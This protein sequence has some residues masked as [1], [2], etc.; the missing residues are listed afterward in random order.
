MSGPVPFVEAQ[1]L[2]VMGGLAP[3][4]ARP[5]TGEALRAMAGRVIQGPGAIC[6]GGDPV[7]LFAS[8]RARIER[9]D[10]VWVAAEADLLN[11]EELRAVAGLD[12][13]PAQ[14]GLLSRLY[15]MEG[16]AFLRRLRGAFAVA[17]WDRRQ[18]A[19]LLA[20]DPF[21]MR[22]LYYAADARGTAFAS[23]LAAL[24]AGLAQ[25]APIEPAAIFSYLNFGFIP[26]PETPFTGI[27]RLPPGHVFHVR[28]G[29][30]KLEPYWDMS[31][32]EER[33]RE[34][35]AAATMYRLSHEAV[36]E[37][38][39]QTDPSEIG[40]FLSGGTDSSTVVGLMTRI[41]GGP[42]RSFSI[43]FHEDRYDELQYAKLAART[44]DATH[45]TRIIK[46]DDALDALPRLV[47]AYDEPFGNNSAIGV[48]FCARMAREHG[49]S[50]LL[51]GDG[52]DEIFGGNE[53]YRTDRIFARYSNLPAALRHGLLE[54]VLLGLPA[55]VP[56]LLGRAQ[57]YIRR[58]NIPNPRRFYSY[59]FHV[60]QNAAEMLEPSFLRQ[61]ASSGPWG[62][63]EEHF[64]R[65]QAT[66]ELNR[67]MYLDLKL[68][69]GD[70]DLFK[71]TRTSEL[72]GVEVRFPFLDRPLV[73]F[74]GTLAPEFK[75]RGLEKRH[76]FKRAFRGL[77]PK[78][79]LA[80]QKHGFGVPTSDW[81]RSHR[82]IREMARDVLLE[83]RTVERGYFRRGV[84]E[85]L[86][87]QLVAD[88]TPFYGDILWT[89]LMLELW[90]RRHVDGQGIAG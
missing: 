60:A 17:L 24:R 42:V 22:R 83:S 28:Q 44:F 54:P 85:R 66:S 67:L 62:V 40:A 15:E 13:A 16:P 30:S 1:A 5:V 7:G 45:H 81:L 87:E 31:Y 57:R 52:G 74:T 18:R 41:T 39:A 61:A 4:P 38:L 80:K 65:V 32:P 76:L 6:T 37:A 47:E 48:Y 86:F 79:I 50:R 33:H 89:L 21:G 25:A 63:L 69:I 90:H 43:G 84:L 82:G 88:S 3:A 10:T 9:S 46:P 56:G 55:G 8:G 14:S 64:A 73:E 59:E 26:A 20:V 51:A 29:Y 72:G 23:R 35:R 12:E 36:R 11:L 58:A 71:V 2:S 49:V 34:D 68:T 27:R 78:E 77:L 75:V 19:L 53:R 70:N